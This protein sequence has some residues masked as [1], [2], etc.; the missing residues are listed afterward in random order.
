MN[1]LLLGSGDWHWS[2][3]TTVDANS[4]NRAD[5]TAA[6]PPLPLSV[7]DQ[8]WDVIMAIHFIEHLPPWDAFAL[9]KECRE[10][11]ASDGVLILE[12]PNILQCAKVLL[13][14]EA[15][16]GGAPGQFDLWGFYGDPTHHDVW[17]LHRWGYTPLS[18]VRLLMEVG[19]ARDQIEVLPAM[20]HQPT[21]DF[22][23][24]ARR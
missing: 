18:L 24:E 4:D 1:Q 23:V 11:L 6:I 16:P 5:F 21:R 22:R 7:R 8:Q 20:F 14:L 17:M 3:W 12:Q 15:A 19:F 2:G 10:C 13:G 9:L